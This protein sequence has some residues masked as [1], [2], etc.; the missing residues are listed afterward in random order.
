MRRERCS[1]TWKVLMVQ[2]TFLLLVF[3][4][5]SIY[6]INIL[7]KQFNVHVAFLRLESIH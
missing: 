2:E 7:N 4:L 3:S 1:E 6:V 5:S